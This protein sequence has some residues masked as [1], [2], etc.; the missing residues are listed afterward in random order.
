MNI[1]KWGLRYF[2][3]SGKKEEHELYGGG[4]YVGEWSNDTNIPHGRGIHIKGGWIYIGHLKNGAE[5]GKYIMIHNDSVFR[6]GE[7]TEDAY[8]ELHNK[9]IKYYADGKTRQFDV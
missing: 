6:V 9:G 4:Y 2:K 5:S 3:Y 1:C 8:G 7:W